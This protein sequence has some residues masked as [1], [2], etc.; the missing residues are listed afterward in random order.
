MTVHP[1]P[2]P[3]ATA[4]I[5]KAGDAAVPE[6][7][8]AEFTALDDRDPRKVAAVCIA[9]EKWRT[10]AFADDQFPEPG[11]ARARRIADARRPR[12]GDFTGGQ[13]RWDRSG[14][15]SGE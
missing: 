11:S 2:H 14:V 6:Y 13:V 7:G 15:A 8:S 5:G 3:W 1:L 10:R 9:A 4:L 12:P